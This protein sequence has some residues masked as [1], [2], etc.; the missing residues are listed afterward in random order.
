M[1]KYFENI[2]E[3]VFIISTQSWNPISEM[4]RASLVYVDLI[5]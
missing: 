4:C 1:N 3:S 2:L 5:G